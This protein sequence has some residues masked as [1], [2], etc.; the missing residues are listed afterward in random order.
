MDG[1]AVRG[2]AENVSVAV[3]ESIAAVAGT[4]PL[5]MEPPLYEAVDT[6]ALDKLFER[7][8]PERVEFEYDGHEVTVTG[9]GTVTVDGE[10]PR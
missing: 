8:D 9:D 1:T 4:D 6:D 10:T 2:D 3:I 7:G 5:E